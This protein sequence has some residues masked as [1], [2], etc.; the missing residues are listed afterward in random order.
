MALRRN[1]Q[2]IKIISLSSD[3]QDATTAVL[4]YNDHYVHVMLW[5]V[6]KLRR[7]LNLLVFLEF[8]GQGATVK[9]FMSV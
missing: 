9:P 1:N 8:S 6:K 5:M 4:A 2:R 3:I 7:T